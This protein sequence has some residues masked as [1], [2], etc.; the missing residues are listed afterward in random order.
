MFYPLQ[1]AL[2]AVTWVVTSRQDAEPLIR[3]QPEKLLGSRNGIGVRAGRREDFCVAPCHGGGRIKEVS[4]IGPGQDG[5]AADRL[6][7]KYGGRICKNAHQVEADGALR[8]VGGDGS[9]VVI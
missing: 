5:V 7:V 8:T 9:D 2:Q 6:D 4:G 3:L 1:K